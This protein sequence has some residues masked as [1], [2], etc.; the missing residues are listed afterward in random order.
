M[1]NLTVGLLMDFNSGMTVLTKKQ[2]GDKYK[3]VLRLYIFS[4]S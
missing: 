2:S 3:E 4:Y 1:V